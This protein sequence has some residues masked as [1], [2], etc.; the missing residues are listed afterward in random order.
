[1]S[2]P[3]RVKTPIL[4][5]TLIIVLAVAAAVIYF[6]TRKAPQPAAEKQNAGQEIKTRK[7]TI[8]YYDPQADKDESG[9]VLCTRAGLVP[10]ARE[11]PLTNT[12]IQD[13]INLL[14]K[15]DLTAGE[16]QSGIT[17]EFPLPGLVLIGAD[18]AGGILTLEFDDPLNKT[19]GGAC[20]SGVLWFQIEA[21]ARQAAGVDRVRFVPDTL[22]QP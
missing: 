20:R 3:M 14:L 11:I 18:L 10:L 7:I 6:S 17:T 9:N 13:A 1:M 22:F 2:R 5:I 15:G 8:Y 16:K 19:G 4:K 21:T 12:P